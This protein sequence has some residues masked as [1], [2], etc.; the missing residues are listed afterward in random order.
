MLPRKYHA[1]QYQTKNWAF[2]KG[3]C[4]RADLPGSI[5]RDR[6]P[7]RRGEMMLFAHFSLSSLTILTVFRLYFQLSAYIFR[8]SSHG[9]NITLALEPISESYVYS[10]F[11]NYVAE[12]SAYV[13]C[14]L[15]Q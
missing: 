15:K 9:L 3:G 6:I 7:A 1:N 2:R 5:G 12:L 14:S 13:A 8:I 4:R 11:L 10:L